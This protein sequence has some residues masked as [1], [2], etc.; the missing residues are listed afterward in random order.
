MFK[1]LLGPLRCAEPFGFHSRLAAA[2]FLCSREGRQILVATN[3][4]LFSLLHPGFWRNQAAA[5]D[6]EPQEEPSSCPPRWAAAEALQRPLSPSPAAW[7][8]LSWPHKLHLAKVTAIP[9]GDERF[10]ALSPASTGVYFIVCPPFC[11]LWLSPHQGNGLA[12]TDSRAVSY[13]QCIRC[14]LSLRHTWC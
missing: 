3:Y 13:Y 14:L 2:Q 8:T 5:G 11:L 10:L 4:S 1:K 9:Q 6:P 7:G 12:V